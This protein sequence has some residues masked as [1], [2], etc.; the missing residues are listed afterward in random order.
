VPFPELAL[1]ETVMEAAPSAVSAA[2]KAFAKI[3]LTL[4]VIGPRGDGYHEIRSFVCGVDLAD[5]VHGSTNV[6]GTA[7]VF[8]DDPSLNGPGNLAQQA[9]VR[10]AAFAGVSPSLRMEIRKKIPIGGGMGGGSS[11]AA[12]AL[13]ICRTLW[14]L[15][16]SDGVLASVGAELGSDVPLFFHLPSAVIAGRGEIV[17]SRRM[18]WTG[19]AMLV[20]AGSSVPTPEVYRAWRREECPGVGLD[21]EDCV[22]DAS[23]AAELM[24]LSRNDLEPAVFR[25][26]SETA[27]V[28]S[29]LNRRGLGPIRVSGAGSVM[30]RLFDDIDDARAV[31]ARVRERGMNV[32]TEVVAVPAGPA[33]VLCKERLNG[34]H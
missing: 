5:E 25:V 33:P 24:A 3:N 18:S 31:A 16:L 21:L 28:F 19:W 8:C 30:Y 12:A 13:R 23:S 4:Q 20:A 17:E 22:A 15:E 11:D 26:S 2:T 10:L 29:E 27:G 14:G 32:R 9:A 34:D 6:E 1:T 7:E